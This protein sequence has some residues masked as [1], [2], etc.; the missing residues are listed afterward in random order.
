MVSCA[1]PLIFAPERF[2]LLVNMMTFLR[3]VIQMLFFSCEIMFNTD[4]ALDYLILHH[5]LVCF[6]LILE[7]S[8]AECEIFSKRLAHTIKFTEIN[9][10]EE[11]CSTAIQ[12]NSANI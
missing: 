2:E 9:T 1:F 10:E 3:S 12:R 4:Y 6:A 11:I 8:I 7:L 5:N